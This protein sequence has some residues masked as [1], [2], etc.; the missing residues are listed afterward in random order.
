MPAS[1]PHVKVCGLT[2]VDDAE[3]AQQLGAWA[4]GMVFAQGSPR[5]CSREQARA[6]SAR[7]R[8]KAKL[9][10]VFVNACSCTET[11]ARRTARR[12]PGAP[13]RA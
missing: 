13:A 10:G 4:L 6:I 1:V 5:R 8:R 3:L 7:L 2:R 11:R 12:Q 9:C